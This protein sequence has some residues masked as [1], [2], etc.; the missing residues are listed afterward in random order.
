MWKFNNSLPLDKEYVKLVMDTIL[1]VKR[2]CCLSQEGQTSSTR[3]TRHAG[4]QINDKCFVLV[5][6][7][8][9]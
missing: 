8:L 6:F 5:F 9:K 4:Y 3:G 2:Q 7:C 1:E